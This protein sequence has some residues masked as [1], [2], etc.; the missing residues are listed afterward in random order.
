VG[1]TPDGLDYYGGFAAIT[2][3][4][5]LLSRVRMALNLPDSQVVL[6]LPDDVLAGVT[7][8]YGLAVVRAPVRAPMLGLRPKESAP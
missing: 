1:G 4:L 2:P 6:L 5:V 3:L 7:S 8:A